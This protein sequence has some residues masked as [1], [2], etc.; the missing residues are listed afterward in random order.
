[1]LRAVLVAA[2]SLLMVTGRVHRADAQNGPGAAKQE[3]SLFYPDNEKLGFE[4]A[5]PPSDL[6]LDALLKTKEARQVKVQLEGYD[7]DGLRD[8]FEVVLVDLG[9]SGDEDYVAHGKKRPMIGAD[10]DWFWIV[11]VQRG[12]ANVIL[13]SNGWS[14]RLLERKTNG[15]RDIERAYGTAAFSGETLYR[16]NGSVYDIAW[17]HTRENR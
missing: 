15:F 5:R 12:K 9:P 10:N 2:F 13:F 16:F 1:M 6:V 3:P 14:L 7:R 4:H 17:D 8:L 11:R